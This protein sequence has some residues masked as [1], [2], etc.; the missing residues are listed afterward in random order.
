MWSFL[1]PFFT[2]TPEAPLI[3]PDSVQKANLAEAVNK[4]IHL[5]VGDM[6]RSLLSESVWI[7]VKILIALAIYFI[8]RWIVRRIVRQRTDAGRAAAHTSRAGGDRR[9][10]ELGLDRFRSGL[11]GCRGRCVERLR[12]DPRGAGRCIEQQYVH[13]GDQPFSVISSS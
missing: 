2:E 4:I 12:D 13:R 9:T 11:P 8:G 1:V 6:L 10:V 3:L 5:D 7:L